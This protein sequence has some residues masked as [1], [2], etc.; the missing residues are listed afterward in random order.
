MRAKRPV[1]AVLF[2]F[3]SVGGCEDFDPD[4]DG[5]FSWE[6]KLMDLVDVS[7]GREVPV[8]IYY[9]ADGPTEFVRT[10]ACPLVILSH[11]AGGSRNGFPDCGARLGSWGFVGVVV[12]HV[13]SNTETIEALME[14]GMTLVE[15]I[16]TVATDTNEWRN[17]PLDV[18]FILDQ[19][20]AWNVSDPDLRGKIDLSSIGIYGNS[21][22]GFTSLAISGALVNLPEGLTALGDAR[23]G[24]AFPVSPPPPN[25]LGGIFASESF[26]P[27]EIPMFLAS[28]SEDQG[29]EIDP[30]DRLIPFRIMQG[31]GNPT[32][33][34]HLWIEGAHHM[35]FAYT[36][37]Q[38]PRA[39]EVQRIVLAE[40][41]AF[42]DRFLRARESSERYLT[43]EY[44]DSLTGAN[45]PD[46][47]LYQGAVTQ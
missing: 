3:L 33:L 29:L 34:W 27:V 30:E 42:F 9:P 41:T 7:R 38:P 15:A 24:A 46:T 8:K 40:M 20:E 11:G 1:R 13:G 14:Q 28:G 47:T 45:I 22:G 16:H 5:P 31:Q 2:L 17:R 21:Y 32:E 26:L 35:D 44:A 19:A 10:G 23:V 18:T 12:E 36:E 6:T 4:Q 43:E 25:G 37:G 39:D